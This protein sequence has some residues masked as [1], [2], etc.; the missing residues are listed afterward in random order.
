MNLTVGTRVWWYHTDECRL[1]GTVEVLEE[2]PGVRPDGDPDLLYLDADQL[3]T[4]LPDGV[5]PG[6]PDDLYHTDKTSLSASGAKLLLPPSVP[7]KYRWCMD[8]PPP[9]KPVFDFG[10]LVHK[11]V[12]GEGADI[13]VIHAKDWRTKSAQE[14]KTKA[15]NAGLIPVLASEHDQAE[16]MA[17]QVHQ[18]P[19]AG[20]LFR[21]GDAETSLCVTDPDTGVRLRARPDYMN[22]YDGRLTITDYKT[23]ADANP[24]TFGRTAFQWSYHLQFAWYVHVARLLELDDNPAFLFVVQEKTAPYL[25]SVCELDAEAFL[26][27]RKQM[28]Q[29][30]ATFKTCTEMDAW[31]GY[32]PEIQSLSL[33]AWAYSV[34]QQTIGDLLA[35]G[36]ND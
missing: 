24:D 33:P 3:R 22:Q 11:L 29:A 2:R 15:H 31:W 7:A 16:K 6:I 5:H 12:L 18:H 10:K 20:A 23:A 8:N 21:D 19:L 9:P 13:D 27:G 4:A 35:T 30:I 32:P 14:A 28:Q 36:G 34:G 25:V 1:F 17:E 26:L